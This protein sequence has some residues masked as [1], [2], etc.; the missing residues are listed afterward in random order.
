M[1]GLVEAESGFH[2]LLQNERE[3]LGLFYGM[4][5]RGFELVMYFKMIW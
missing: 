2:G 4:E 1:F 3:K 5:E